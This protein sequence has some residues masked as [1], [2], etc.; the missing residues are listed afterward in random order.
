MSRFI[1]VA[2]RVVLLLLVLAVI[3]VQSLLVPLVASEVVAM[4][5]EVSQLRWPYILI[6]DLVLACFL[7]AA[8]AVW[9][10][11][12]FVARRDTFTPQAVGWVNLIIGS[13][14]AAMLLALGG[15]L[16]LAWLGIGGPPVLLVTAGS[17]LLG[18]GFILLMLVLRGLLRDA[19][20]LRSELSEV[21]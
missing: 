7:P 12:G 11:L 9:V 21:I 5:P 20:A 8:L 14:T 1:I 16:H 19:T 13:A 10:L 17:L 4:Y 2:L 6:T 15:A 3:A 18:P